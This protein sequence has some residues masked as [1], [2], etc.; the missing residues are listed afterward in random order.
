MPL[1]SAIVP[2]RSNFDIGEGL[3]V[4]QPLELHPAFPRKILLVSGT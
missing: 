2:D 4:F 3:E 1:Q